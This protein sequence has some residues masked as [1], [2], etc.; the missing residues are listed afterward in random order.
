MHEKVISFLIL[1]IFVFMPAIPDWQHSSFPQWF[2]VYAP[3]LL[4]ILL[5][6]F[7]HARRRNPGANNRA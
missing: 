6:M 2:E 4:L 3:W 7:A 5:C 1:G